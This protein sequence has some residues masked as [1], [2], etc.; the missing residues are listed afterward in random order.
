M[1]TRLFVVRHGNTFGDDEAPRRIGRRTDLPLTA[2]GLV[3]AK[4]LGQW[5]A[6]RGIHFDHAAAGPLARTRETALLILREQAAPPPLKEEDWLAEID[7]GP[8]ENQTEDVVVARIGVPA[9]VAWN[10]AGIAP[11]DWHVDADMR[12]DAWRRQFA[13]IVSGTRL[14]VTSNGVA[15]FALLM[16]SPAIRP[17]SLTLR[18]GSLGEIAV[19]DTADAIQLV[20]W[21][22]R[23]GE[24]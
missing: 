16:L 20:S 6:R 17:S 13:S 18:P 8:D 2:A 4:A 12:L 11:P 19:G 21:N 5:F 22:L 15:R 14:F 3:Q 10:L 9:L 23:P 7:H 24:R 1:T